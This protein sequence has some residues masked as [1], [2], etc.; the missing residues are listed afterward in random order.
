MFSR[1]ISSE[2]GGPT[3]WKGGIW[4]ILLDDTMFGKHYWRFRDWRQG[5][6]TWSLGPHCLRLPARPS[7]VP[8]IIWA[9]NLTPCHVETQ[10]I[11][12]MVLIEA[13][14]SQ[15]SSGKTELCFIL[16]FT[17]NCS[18]SHWLQWPSL[19]LNFQD[20]KPG[21]VCIYGCFI[22]GDSTGQASGRF[23]VSRKGVTPEHLRI[24]KHIVYPKLHFFFSFL[25]VRVCTLYFLLQWQ[26]PK[27][28]RWRIKVHRVSLETCHEISRLSY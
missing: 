10:S 14:F 28:T 12:G 4:G 20:K 3:P 9:Q 25:W 7:C 16:N 8:V 21:R 18:L 22:G 2:R 15:H 6:Q 5:C 24:E 19:C 27:Q 13:E 17:Q 23:I 11:G 26:D 1:T